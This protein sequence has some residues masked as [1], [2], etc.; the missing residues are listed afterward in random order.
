M[1]D[2][3]TLNPEVFG[4]DIS[5]S[6]LKIIKLNQKRGNLKL[7]SFGETLIKP[8]IIKKGKIINEVAFSKSIE[9]ALNNINGKKLKTKYAIASLSEESVFLQVIKI[10][11]MAKEEIESAVRFEA[12][13]YIPIPLEKTYLDFQIISSNEKQNYFEILIVAALKE[14]IDPYISC[15]EKVGIKLKAL[16]VEPMSIARALIKKG[17]NVSPILL[18]DLGADKTSLVVV[19]DNSIRFSFSIPISADKF[20]EAIARALE[21]KKEKA[22]KLKTKYGLKGPEKIHLEGEK[23]EEKFKKEVICEEKI[24]EALIPILTD[25]IEQ[26]NIYLDYYQYHEFSEDISENNKKLEKI[27]ICGGGAN[28]KGICT[29]LSLELKILTE[30]G[31]P[32]IN[33]SKE[34]Q[35]PLQ[36]S[37]KYTTAIGLALRG[38]NKSQKL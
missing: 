7:V 24:F 10:P 11:K 28:L 26:I 8:G 1:L 15:F 27:I 9:K 4:I 25:L 34:I 31:N 29:F 21:I 19:R 33:I 16:E 38:I 17:D 12:E 20:T 18:I 23:G 14:I 5:D 13:N 2:F 30:P 32:W 37:L 22:E 36:D 3:L 35:M 6:S